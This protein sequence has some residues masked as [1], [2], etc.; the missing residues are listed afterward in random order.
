MWTIARA[1]LI[2]LLIVLLAPLASADTVKIDID[3]QWTVPSL[4][5]PVR[6]TGSELWENGVG[7]V[8]PKNSYE[9][10]HVTGTETITHQTFHDLF[11]L[12]FGAPPPNALPPYFWLDVET[13]DLSVTGFLIAFNDDYS[14]I[15]VLLPGDY[16]ISRSIFRDGSRP[17]GENIFFPTEGYQRVS[18]V[19]VP[20][21]GSLLLLAV[22]LVCLVGARRLRRV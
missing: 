21:L 1:V 15:P 7:Y 22:G 19:S 11:T 6:F 2:V 18:A 12:L 5:T 3:L 13:F 20:E 10:W 17:V 16:D 8:V 4:P 14:H 9:R